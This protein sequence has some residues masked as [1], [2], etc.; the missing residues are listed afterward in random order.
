MSGDGPRDDPNG[1]G[2]VLKSLLR[3]PTLSVRL[4]GN[5]DMRPRDAASD[6]RDVGLGNVG[7]GGSTVDGSTPVGVPTD[8][9]QSPED[10][11]SVEESLTVLSLNSSLNAAYLSH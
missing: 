4:I 6:L 8:S 9:L 5:G 10:F 7:P 11:V 1:I 3:L 2:V